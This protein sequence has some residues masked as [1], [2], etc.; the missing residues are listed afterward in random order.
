[1]LLTLGINMEI[2]RQESPL[3]LTQSK[4]PLAGGAIE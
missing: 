4:Y 2:A 1:M 3:A